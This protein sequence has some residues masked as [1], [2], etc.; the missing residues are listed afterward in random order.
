M[1]ELNSTAVVKNVLIVLLLA[2]FFFVKI[3]MPEMSLVHL[4]TS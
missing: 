4:N 1:T 2:L 3:Q